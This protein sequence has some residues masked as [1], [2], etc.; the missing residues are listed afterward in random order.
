[1]RDPVGF[2]EFDKRHSQV[3]LD[4]PGLCPLGLE[5]YIDG[6]EGGAKTQLI[7]EVIDGVKTGKWICPPGG[8]PYAKQFIDETGRVR[9]AWPVGGA[10]PFF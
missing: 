2:M 4:N 6:R 5:R 8:R 1:M 9:G 7:E 3:H 10:W